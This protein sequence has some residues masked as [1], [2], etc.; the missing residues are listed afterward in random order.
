MIAALLVAWLLI[1]DEA[2][3]L[4]LQITAGDPLAL[5]I[6][7]WQLNQWSKASLQ[8]VVTGWWSSHQLRALAPKLRPLFDNKRQRP[9]LEH[10]RRVRFSTLLAEAPDLVLVFDCSSA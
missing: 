10:Q 1:E 9:L 8:N 3:E 6:S 7:S 5:P 2:S 4:R